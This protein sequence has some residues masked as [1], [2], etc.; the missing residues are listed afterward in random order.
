MLGAWLE[1]LKGVCTG[2]LPGCESRSGPDGASGLY[3]AFADLTLMGLSR[4]K[5]HG[6]D[7]VSQP[8]G[9][10]WDLQEDWGWGAEVWGRD[11]QRWFSVNKREKQTKAL[12]GWKK[13]TWW[14]W[15]YGGK[16]GI[17]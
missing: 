1:T 13:S 6:G 16:L 3:Q 14:S 8:L 12:L 7:S 9:P 17:N 2:E 4:C 5:G 10:S 15:V 11:R